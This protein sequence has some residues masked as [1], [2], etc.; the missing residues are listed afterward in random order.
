MNAV[1]TGTGLSQT[2]AVAFF[3]VLVLSTAAVGIARML[4]DK[5][6]IRH[7]LLLST[8]LAC[9]A[10]PIV[11]AAT[12][13]A[14]A[15]VV[16]IPIDAGPEVWMRDQATAAQPFDNP[17]PRR[18]QPVAPQTEELV[19]VAPPPHPP[20]RSASPRT[21]AVHWDYASGLLALWGAGTV[22]LAMFSLRS[23]LRGR[24]IAQRALPVD[25]ASIS[26]PRDVARKRVGLPVAPKLLCSENTAGP[27][28]HGFIRPVVILP[29]RLA[30]GLPRER[31]TDVL[32]HEFAHVRR[33]DT[34]VLALESLAR[35]LLWPVISVHWLLRSLENAREEICD[36]YV[37][38]KRD[39]IHYAETL[40]QLAEHVRRAGRRANQ[41]LE[42]GILSFQGQLENRVARI[43]DEGRDRSVHLSPWLLAPLLMAGLACGVLFSGTRLIADDPVHAPTAR[44][45]GPV[46]PE[47]RSLPPSEAEVAEAGTRP[48]TVRG[49]VHDA[50]G[51]V[52]AGARVFLVASSWQNR[53]VAEMKSDKQGRYVF[54]EVEFPAK[55]GSA[56]VFATA[57]RHGLTWHG[58]MSLMD[59][60]KLAQM[61]EEIARR[62]FDPA[63]PVEM[64]LVFAKAATL[65]GTI[66]NGNGKPIADA[67]V[68]IRQLDYLDPAGKVKH[69]NYREFS[70][71]SLAPASYRLATT[72]ASGK[73]RFPSLPLQTYALLSVEARRLCRQVA[74]CRDH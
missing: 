21:R 48:I 72:D 8:L 25:S 67:R 19:S 36:N 27:A 71:L 5:P 66:R 51:R 31:L 18:P 74:L 45:F 15:P 24:H 59:P 73:F 17:G 35:C 23:Y 26:V 41:G 29:K 14:A 2:M 40:L 10:A 13:I 56:S 22:L 9:L 63:K 44:E 39:G 64:N 20:I 70:A 3:S 50:E 12:W 65:I 68:R 11:S 38:L 46:G 47:K 58:M 54:Q 53:M 55:S 1:F 32:I 61:P 52:V 6:V 28:V 62:S 42:V 30:S 49:T 16:S 37:V 34:C 4:G 43:L 69:V 33:R 7:G 60:G 57:D